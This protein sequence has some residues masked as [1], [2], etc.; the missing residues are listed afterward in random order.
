MFVRNVVIATTRF[1]L[2]FIDDIVNITTN[3]CHTGIILFMM[4][5][6]RI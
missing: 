4:T 3:I 2:K 5:G 1:I 6:I